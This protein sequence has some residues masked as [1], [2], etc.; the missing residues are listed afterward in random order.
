M[1]TLTTLATLVAL[2]NPVMAEHHEHSMDLFMSLDTNGDQHISPL[3]AKGHE[4]L[5]EQFET[6]DLDTDGQLSKAELD[7][8]KMQ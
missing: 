5:L 8:F 1:K 7:L 4:E 6:L 3:E 2:S